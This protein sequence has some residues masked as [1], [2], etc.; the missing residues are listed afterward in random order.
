MSNPVPPHRPLTDIN[1]NSLLAVSH[2]PTANRLHNID[3]ALLGEEEL[4]ELAAT[5]NPSV[6]SAVQ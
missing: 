1:V 2:A 6:P 5:V 3:P 4:A